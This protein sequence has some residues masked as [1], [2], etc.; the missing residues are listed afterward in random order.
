LTIK[1]YRECPRYQKCSVNNCPLHPIF[2]ELY[3]DPEDV[4]VKCTLEKEVRHKIGSKYPDLLKFQGLTPREWTGKK[5]FEG[6]SNQDK[7]LVRERARRAIRSA[8]Q[9]EVPLDGVSLP[10]PQV[11]GEKSPLIRVV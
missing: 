11:A 5:R 10:F 4:Q 7:E 9:P 6:L 8:C 2:P 1:P 3:L